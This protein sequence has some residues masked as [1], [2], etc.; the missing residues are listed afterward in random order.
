MKKTIIGLSGLI[1]LTFFIIFA[2]NA[3]SNDQEGRK[4]N[5][6][7]SQNISPSSSIAMSPGYSGSKMANCCNGNVQK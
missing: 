2:V 6:E 3:E 5:T 4:A 7:V 1:V